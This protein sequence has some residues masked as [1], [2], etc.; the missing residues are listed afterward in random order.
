M[1]ISSLLLAVALG[2]S[3]S[4]AA[5]DN[6]VV[7]GSFEIFPGTLNQNG[8]TWGQFSTLDGWQQIGSNPDS[9]E[10]QLATNY[11]KSPTASGT[12]PAFNPSSSDGSAHYLEINANRLDK[13]GQTIT[14]VIGQSYTFK[15][16]YSGRSDSGTTNGIPN[17]S[18]VNVYWDNHSLANLDE[19]PNSGWKIFTYTVKATSTSTQFEFDSVGPTENPSYGSYLDAVSVTAVPEPETY[20]MMMVGL[21]LMGFMVRRRNNKEV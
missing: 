14:T 15:F 8:Q 3:S 6:L 13:V 1:K 18:K 19:L 7:N 5:A 16:D 9:F 10:I 4:M 20:G 2:A 21:G 11:Q 17:N 12:Y